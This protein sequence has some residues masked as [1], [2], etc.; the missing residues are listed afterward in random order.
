M[1]QESLDSKLDTSW[2]SLLGVAFPISIG[3]FVEF[4]I[5]FIDNYFVAKINGNAMSGV[6]FVGLI[7]LS[8][9]MIGVGMSNA[10][11]ILIARRKGEGKLNA[12]GG[13]FSNAMMFSVL[14]AAFQFTLLYYVAPI[15]MRKYLNSQDVLG[16]MEIF[17]TVRSFGF[18][19]HTPTL[20]LESFWSGIAKTRILIYPVIVTSLLTIGLDYMLIFGNWGLP[21][22]GISGAAWATIIAEAAAFFVLLMITFNSK[23]SRQYQLIT[24]LRLPNFSETKSILSLGSPISLQLLLSLGIWTVFYSFI[25]KLGEISLQASF[26]VRHLYLLAYVSVGGFS[27]TAK[28]YVSGLIAEKRQSELWPLIYKI[29]FLNF[30][31]IAILTHGLWLYPQK[32]ASLFSTNIEAI[33]E[34]VRIMHIVFPAML[35]FAFTSILLA[36]V[37]GSGNTLAGAFVEVCTSAIYLSAAYVFAIEWKL[38]VH[39]VWTADYLYFVMIGVVSMVFLFG[40][41]WKYKSI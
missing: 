29:M 27:T 1:N 28:T 6:A 15:L 22:M 32:I 25:E 40:G 10:S 35:C 12:V 2:K 7:Y 38:P 34:A 19:F 11:Q 14:L 36:A 39:L 21:A 18:F 26:V 20:M 4:I 24:A 8:L 31:G 41:Q 16:Y 23:E 13:I 33:I 17:I 37:E 30:C 5:V 9:S 3:I